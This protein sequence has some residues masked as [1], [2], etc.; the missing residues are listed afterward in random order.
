MT[1]II[2]RSGSTHLFTDISILKRIGKAVGIFAVGLSI[3]IS[4]TAQANENLTFNGFYTLDFSIADGDVNVI[5]NSDELLQLENESLSLRNSLLGG[6][7]RYGLTEN[8]SV[9]VQGAAYFDSDEDATSELNWA[10]VS[11][12][13]G[14]DFTARIGKFQVPFLSGTELR[15]I[16][17]TR[18][19]A[20]PLIPGNGASGFGHHHGIEVLH[21]YSSGNWHWRFQGAVGEPEHGLS[22][23]DGNLMALAAAELR[24][25]S[26]MLRSSVIRMDYDVSTPA[27]ETL[28]DEANSLL[29]SFE[30]EYNLGDGAI[31][32]G[33]SDA[34]ADLAPDD[35]MYYGSFGYQ[36]GLFHPY[37][38][39]V[40]REQFYEA[41][42]RD[43]QP[44]M[45][46]PPPGGGRPPGMRPP[47]PPPV[48]EPREGKSEV[49]SFGL[50]VRWEAADSTSVKL[51]Y[52]FEKNRDNTRA[53]EGLVENDAN[54]LSLVIEGVF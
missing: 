8:T 28:S 53:S 14:N 26:L 33:F 40:H 27:G 18:T 54:I 46:R 25:H 37:V 34:N 3:T 35:S 50:G 23:I 29:A 48:V 13:F 47:P 21:N 38:F 20:R 45:V 1:D 39:A 19:W 30:L 11:H 36:I 9:F 2:I 15:N 12:D 16:G 6:Q 5:S 24:V 4:A 10:Y 44:P 17:Y 42:P 32:A 31:N 22:I 49:D 41:Q 7:V 43:A 51:Q 52:Q